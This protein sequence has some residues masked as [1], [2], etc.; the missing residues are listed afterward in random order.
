MF[1]K[2]IDFFKPYDPKSYWESRGTEYIKEY[3]QGT[4]AF[5]KP[6]PLLDAGLVEFLRNV[7]FNSLLE[8]GCNFGKNLKLVSDAFPKKRIAGLDISTTALKEAKEFLKGRNIEFFNSDAIKMPFKDKEFDVVI[9]GEVLEHVPYDKFHPT[10]DEFIRITEKYLI[11]I[12]P[13]Q[14]RA[15]PVAKHLH[16]RHV[17][18]YDY[19]KEIENKPELELLSVLPVEKPQVLLFAK[20]K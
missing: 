4:R 14:S 1:Q 8:V 9:A 19:E 7:K 11:L 20:R 5:E 3:K 6:R 18:I 17:F 13:Y 12:S 15:N 16:A 10:L 2:I